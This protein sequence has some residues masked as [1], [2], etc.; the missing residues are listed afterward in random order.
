M[1]VEES[2]LRALSSIAGSL[3]DIVRVMT[4]LNENLV[5]FAKQTK[6]SDDKYDKLMEKKGDMMA[7][8]PRTYQPPE[9]YAAGGAPE[10]PKAGE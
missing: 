5:A 6:E 3:K 7:L 1:S 8:I 2:K 9:G 10:I 4:A